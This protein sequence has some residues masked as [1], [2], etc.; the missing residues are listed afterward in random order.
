MKEN[1]IYA[2]ID[3]NVIVSAYYSNKIS[4]PAIIIASLLEGKIIPLFN[5]EIIDEYKDVLSRSKFNFSPK[6][7]ADFLTAFLSHGL[8]M[9][10]EKVHGFDF[11]DPKDVVFYEVKMSKDDAYLVT[12]NI[13][14]FPKEPT[15]VTPAEMVRIL[16][17]QGLLD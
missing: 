8:E 12:G 10:G 6:I 2:I 14:H 3:T 15:V 1:K 17:D 7:I 16:K 11:P 9:K 13:K 4:N 5:K